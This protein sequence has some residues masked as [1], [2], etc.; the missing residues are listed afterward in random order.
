M[1]TS[2]PNARTCT[3]RL[4]HSMPEIAETEF[5]DR[6][7]TVR[8]VDEALSQASVRIVILH[9]PAGTGKTAMIR[10]FRRRLHDCDPE[11]T[12]QV[13][14]IVYLSGTGYRPITTDTLLA[15]LI[16]VVSDDE[17]RGGLSGEL[18]QP[19]DWSNKL[20][21]VLAELDGHTVLVLVDDADEVVNSAGFRD[22]QMNALVTALAYDDAARVRLVLV[23]RDP[24]AFRSRLRHRTRPVPLDK[25]LE[26]SD[27]RD[28]LADLGQ[29]SEPIIP[30]PSVDVRRCLHRLSAGNPRCIELVY[31]FLRVTGRTD[32]PAIVSE[33]D[34]AGILADDM[35]GWLLKRISKVLPHGTRRTLQALAVFGCPVKAAAVESVLDGS[36]AAVVALVEMARWGVVR[37]YDDD[38]YFVPPSEVERVIADLPP[39]NEDDFT[40]RP[41][42]LSERSLRSRAADYFAKQP[43]GAPLS[44]EQ[45]Q[46][47]LHEVR[48][49]ID[50]RQYDRAHQLMTEID[51]KY[52]TG[53]GQGDVLMPWRERIVGHLSNPQRE[54]INASFLVAARAQDDDPTDDLALLRRASKQHG[55]EERPSAAVSFRLQEAVVRASEQRSSRSVNE[56]LAVAAEC[57]EQ[58][59]RV[60]EAVALGNAAR[61]LGIVGRF[62]SALEHQRAAAV[63]VEHV[64]PGERLGL[65]VQAWLPL[66]LGRLYS[67]LD[68][69]EEALELLEGGAKTARQLPDDQLVARFLDGCAAVLCDHDGAVTAIALATQAAELAVRKR[70]T[71]LIRE[72]AKT[73][74][75]A[76]LVNNEVE[77]ARVAAEAALRQPAS[78]RQLGSLALRGVIAYRQGDRITAR[79]AFAEACVEA[80]TRRAREPRDFV[81]LDQY[82]VALCGLALC[83]HH[84]D[85]LG[86]AVEIFQQSRRVTNAAGVRDHRRLM[87]KQF[88]DNVDSHVIS[89]VRRAIE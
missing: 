39:W 1:G 82:G 87:L 79:R 26:L 2:R 9:G 88:G 53:W 61:H 30:Q 36:V 25:G 43:I 5:R 29:H 47:R 68:R 58:G 6:I 60:A 51:E 48:L 67:Q 71:T 11:L 40:K 37:R 32:L 27:L 80:T 54:L 42:P 20:E 34:E 33:I 15:D 84:P 59:M 49:R 44:V 24:V 17:E 50:A 57:R 64:P 55:T 41:V 35:P 65:A 18:R 22:P 23:T 63:L 89:E 21:A 66:N 78:R 83:T 62:K 13:D 10:E 38:R 73:L 86:E 3:V 14:G 7:A 56:F 72:A 46:P 45:L 69:W 77:N 74:A 12:T 31:A 76:Y 8:Q 70:K 19:G 4:I 75:M 28:F 81:A 16:D 52:L 85:R